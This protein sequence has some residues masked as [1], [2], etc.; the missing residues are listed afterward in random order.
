MF[1]FFTSFI[2]QC[3]QTS[4]TLHGHL[5]DF[6]P[7]GGKWHSTATFSWWRSNILHWDS[8]TNYSPFITMK[9]TEEK[10]YHSSTLCGVIKA[11]SLS[12]IMLDIY[13]CSKHMF[14][15][16]EISMHFWSCS[17]WEFLLNAVNV[18]IK[19]QHKQYFGIKK[20]LSGFIT[21]TRLQ[22]LLEESI[23]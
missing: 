3:W 20:L 2:K 1:L 6:W 11:S 8:P 7:L 21:N 9:V 4:C 18:Y 15:S 22:N 23:K 12:Y 14:L 10:V 17:W 16:L 19:S 13:F 5:S